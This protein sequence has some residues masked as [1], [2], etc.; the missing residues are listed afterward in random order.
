M[1]DKEKALQDK[2]IKGLMECGAFNNGKNCRQCP[3]LDADPH[4][5]VETMAVDALT[6][7]NELLGRIDIMEE[8]T[9]ELLDEIER[10]GKK[11]GK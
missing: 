4:K 3:Y 8:W 5:C 9:N 1:M 7:I 6:V 10:R 11:N 2:V